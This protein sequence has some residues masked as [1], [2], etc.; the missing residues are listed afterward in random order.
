ME[1]GWFLVAAAVPLAALGHPLNEPTGEDPFVLGQ[2][3][4]QTLASCVDLAFTSRVHRLAAK[5][6]HRDIS[7]TV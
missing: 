3:F 2:K 5:R 6:I 1:L 7:V 4:D